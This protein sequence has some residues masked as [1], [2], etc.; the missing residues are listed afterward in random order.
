MNRR[1]S[2]PYIKT[3][4]VADILGVT[5]RTT[6]TKYFS[7]LVDAGILQSAKEVKEVFYIHGD[8]ISIL[9]G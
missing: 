3:K 5:S 2:Q 8:L 7:E 6:L 4:F 1:F 9:E